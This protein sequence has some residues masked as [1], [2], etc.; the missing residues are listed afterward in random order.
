[1]D[2]LD[3]AEAEFLFLWDQNREDKK[4]GEHTKNFW[5]LAPACIFIPTKSSFI[6]SLQRIWLFKKN[7]CRS[8]K[9]SIEAP[10]V[11]S[12]WIHHW[13]SWNSLVTGYLM[14][15]LR[16]GSAE[17]ITDHEGFWTCFLVGMS[18]RFDSFKVPSEW[19]RSILIKIILTRLHMTWL[20]DVVLLN[21]GQP[22][23]CG[24]VDVWHIT[25]CGMFPSF[26]TYTS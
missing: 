2:V 18:E 22:F 17:S 10:R 11:A 21:L 5:N 14:V 8:W 7:Y 20:F 26:M 13:D 9:W 12:S 3:L 1:M 19:F 25:S 23:L 15:F 24:E 6:R 16:F 4:K